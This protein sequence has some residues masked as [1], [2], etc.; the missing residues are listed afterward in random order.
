LSF[1]KMSQKKFSTRVN[2][3]AGQEGEYH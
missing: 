1:E 3:K 2:K